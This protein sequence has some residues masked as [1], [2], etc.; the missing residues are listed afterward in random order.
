MTYAGTDEP[1]E[2]DLARDLFHTSLD[3][4]IKLTDDQTLDQLGGAGLVEFM[5]DM[6]RARNLLSLIDHQTI[7]AAERLDL[8]TVLCQGS[9]RRVLTSV[10]G[11]SRVEAA[12][13]VRAA[14]AV[15]PRISML[16]EALQPVRPVL[17][18][19]QRSGEVSA[20][21]VD[22]IARALDKVDR[23]GFDPADIA[24][25]EQLLTEH[26]AVFPPEDLRI[27]A[28]RVVDGI[29][30]DGSVPNDELNTDR[31]YLHL[32]S[33]RDGA[34]VG[35]FRLT[36]TAGAKLKTLLDPLAKLRVDASGE[37]E[38]RT[39]GKRLHDALEDVCDRQLRAGDVP[40]TGGIPA[41]VI[42]TIDADDLTHR[43]GHGRTADGTMLPTA[44]LLQLA[45]NAD[46]IPTVLTATG[47]VLDLGR[48]RR[49]ASRS[50]TLALIARDAGCSFPACAHPPHYCE[51][52][53]I[54]I[55]R[56]VLRRSE[57]TR[58][59]SSSDDEV[60]G[61][62]AQSQRAERAIKHGSGS[63]V[64]PRI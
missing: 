3:H 12:R 64:D 29:D 60:G 45:N 20:E 32:R 13:R 44:K 30:P 49:I 15:G 27:L 7:A 46:I 14:E 31:C 58:L 33:T 19:A 56:R 50:Q 53:H 51:R 25:G 42:V 37:V 59:S 17:A 11:L 34:Y 63:T 10:L 39:Y 36:G 57:K 4:L 55:A 41:T 40:D 62:R 21:K 18:A 6:E 52:H 43:V 47:A 28:N 61:L 24:R 48:T 38:A 35:D 1:T 54:R 23:R 9:M 26:A 2:P 8:P 22:I 5:Q 16:G